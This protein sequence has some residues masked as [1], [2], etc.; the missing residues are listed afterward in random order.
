MQKS[1]WD[2]AK[3]G[4]GALTSMA[5]WPDE[6]ALTPQPAPPTSAP[7]EILVTYI[8]HATTLIQ[9][10]GLNILT[11]PIYSERASMVS[12]AGPKRVVNPGVPLDE[13][14]EID[15]MEHLG[16]ESRTYHTTLHTNQTGKLTS[17][18][19]DHTGRQNLTKA[20][21]LYSVVWTPE[22]VDWYLDK[23]WKASHATPADFRA[24]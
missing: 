4:F 11:D 15:V 14:P 12:W 10:A 9:V 2:M 23:Q 1:L 19:Y 7:D 21:H 16:H 20:F 17:H 6:V 24:A 13:L 18:P 3:L 5:D 8:N 22:R